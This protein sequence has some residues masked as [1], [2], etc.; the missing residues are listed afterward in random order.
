M[1]HGESPQPVAK[2]LSVLRVCAVSGAA[3][4]GRRQTGGVCVLACGAPTAAGFVVRTTRDTAT[5]A[6]MGNAP[7]PWAR[8]AGSWSIVVAC[9]VPGGGPSFP[10]PAKI[11]KREARPRAA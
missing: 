11:S 7:G 1:P 2:A 6:H 9:D 4:S 8:R 10:S 5:G 3:I